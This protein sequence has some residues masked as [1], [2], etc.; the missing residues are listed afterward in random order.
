MSLGVSAFGCVSVIRCFSVTSCVSVIGCVTATW[1]D[2]VTGYVS[3]TGC[4]LLSVSLNML[5][6][7]LGVLW[8]C[9][10]GCVMYVH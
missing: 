3:V 6:V 8:M 1:C 7:L 4:V 2:N 5:C 10:S 9:F